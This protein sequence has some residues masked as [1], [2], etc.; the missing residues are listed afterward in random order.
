MPSLLLVTADPATADTLSELGESL[1]YRVREV[2]T[3]QMAKEWL[4]M[5]S[6]DFVLVDSR[7]GAITVRTLL[8]ATWKHNA[9]AMAGV[10]NLSGAV[11]SEWEARVWGARVFSGANATGAIRCLLEELPKL[12]ELSKPQRGIM[13]VEDL[14]AARDIIRSYVESLGYADVVAVAGVDQALKELLRQPDRYFCV[15]T[16]LAMPN[17]NGAL[18]I[19]QMRSNPTLEHLPI[20]VLTA[21]PTSEN[22][23]ECVRTGAT[24]F[25]VKPP[26][27]KAL[28]FEL[29]KA[30]RIC[31][32]KQSPRLC[33]PEEAH[34]LEEA[35]LKM[36]SV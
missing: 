7:Y 24:G 21:N 28:R 22:L 20:V 35:L 15:I 26:R 27:K 30:E 3:P 31:S 19:D 29:E 36:S 13:L 1:D 5:Q 25:L 11:D 18:L 16:D 10:F 34:L 9:Q 23:V 2:A 17:K 14:D 32:S 4:S 6:F 33:S 8:E 12:S